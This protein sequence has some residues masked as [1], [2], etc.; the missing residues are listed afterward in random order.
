MIKKKSWG[1]GGR[2]PGPPGSAVGANAGEC[3]SRW[4]V[5]I[6]GEQPGSA[7]EMKMTFSDTKNLQDSSLG[8]LAEIQARNISSA[9][10]TPDGIRSTPVEGHIYGHLKVS[11]EQA[12]T[13][14]TLEF[15]T[16]IRQ[17][18]LNGISKHRVSCFVV[19]KAKP[20]YL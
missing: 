12:F 5:A 13:C 14:S 9:P 20:R 16:D 11:Q 15:Q 6:V 19:V 10:V 3:S 2:A 1:Q 4:I 18:N 17:A 8:C 7:A